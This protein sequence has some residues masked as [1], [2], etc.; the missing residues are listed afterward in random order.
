MET[1]LKQVCIPVGWVPPG[2]ALGGCGGRGCLL[3][4]WCLLQGGL[5]QCNS[6][7]FSVAWAYYGKVLI[8]ANATS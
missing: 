5:L 1:F 2:S 6:M 7:P 3:P 8:L 4:G